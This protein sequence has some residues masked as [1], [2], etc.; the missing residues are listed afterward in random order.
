MKES[1]HYGVLSTTV[2]CDLHCLWWGEGL[3]TKFTWPVMP[4]EHSPLH[5]TGRFMAT[6]ILKNTIRLMMF[7]VWMY[8]GSMGGEE[9]GSAGEEGRDGA[10]ERSKEE[11]GEKKRETEEKGGRQVTQSRAGGQ[12]CL[13]PRCGPTGSQPHFPQAAGLVELGQAVWKPCHPIPPF[14]PPGISFQQ[15]PG[16]LGSV[17]QETLGTLG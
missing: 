12:E 14:F 15:A 3:E 7:V 8:Y 13:G 6:D 1:E 9:R 17:G 2:L 16:N 4:C 5:N 11:R 10:M